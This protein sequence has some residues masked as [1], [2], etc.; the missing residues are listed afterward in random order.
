MAPQE[1]FQKTVQA[2]ADADTWNKRVALVRAIPEHFGLAQHRV[3]YARVAEAVYIADLAPDFAYV[4]W[5]EGYELQEIESAY[6]K[7][8]EL[9]GGFTQV[10]ATSLARVIEASPR[11]LRIFRLLI[12]LTTQEFAATASLLFEVKSLTLAE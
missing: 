10:D 6:A 9:T 7:A 1:S 5:R 8:A 4:H 11:T 3:V 2:I 12:G